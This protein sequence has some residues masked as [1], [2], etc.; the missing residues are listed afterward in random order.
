MG[1]SSSN[2]YP[3]V[4]EILR[5][6][7]LVDDRWWTEEARD[8]GTKVH[9]AAHYLAEGTLDWDTVDP[10]VASRL[11]SYQIFLDEMKP[12]ILAIEET[13]T[14]ELYRYIG[15][16]DIRLRLHGREGVLDI[17]P[18][19]KYPWHPIQLSLYA[20]CF[21]RKLARWNLHLNDEGNRPKLIEHRNRRD[22]EIA[23]AAITIAAWKGDHA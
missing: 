17:K 19:G 11:A 5:A 13:V 2:S 6:A 12:E 3:R 7:G 9:K 4:T 15:H 21:P 23:K 22:W 18:P 8:L 20:G 10:R 16:L 14:N 1:A